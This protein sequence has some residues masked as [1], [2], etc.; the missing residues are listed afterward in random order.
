MEFRI[1][2]P[3]QIHD[4]ETGHRT[5]PTGA[6]QRAL[7][8]ALVVR[9]GH[10][11]PADRLID[12][13]WGEHP[14]ANAAN[15][16]QAHVA[17]LRR[18]LPAPT[19]APTSASA[20]ASASVSAAGDLHRPRLVT[21]PTGYVLHLGAARTDARRFGELAAEGHALAPAD[22]ERCARV[23]RRAVRLWRG[24]ALEG[25]GRGALC[26]AQAALLEENRLLA[27]EALYDACLAT[28]RHHEITAELG[29]LS[30]AH[31]LRERL[32][33]LL[34]TALHRCGRRTEALAVYDRAHQRLGQD[35]GIEPGPV[36]HAGRERILHRPA[37]HPQPPAPPGLPGPCAPSGDG[38]AQELRDEI[39]VLRGRVDQLAREQQRLLALLD[40]LTPNGAAT[41]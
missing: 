29:A 5:V 1:L 18:L 11:V 24:A 15:A 39:G 35:L 28:G 19:P 17:R 27:L 40:R 20:S 9:A 12:E 37:P 26:T 10:V 23:L 21:R 4:T 30:A 22:P 3:M 32:Y 25:A 6:K 2:G 41:R 13:L 38:P 34:L 7:L 16:L 33:E 31:P 8:G 14:P 36:L